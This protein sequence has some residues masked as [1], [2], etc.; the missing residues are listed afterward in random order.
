[1]GFLLLLDSGSDTQVPVQLLFLGLEIGRFYL[2]NHSSVLNHIVSVGQ[3]SG[4]AEVLL[5]QNDGESPVTQFA[6]DIIQ[7]FEDNRR[8]PF[9]DLVQ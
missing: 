1:V 4:K 6:D 5:N 7:G 9:G 8:K 3:R 2:L